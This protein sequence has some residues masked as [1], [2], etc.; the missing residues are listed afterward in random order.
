[1]PYLAWSDELVCGIESVDC[2]HKKLVQLLNEVHEAVSSG[3][4]HEALINIF[5]EL[6]DYTLVHFN[7]EEEVFAAGRY[8]RLTEHKALH[9]TLTQQVIERRQELDA[10]QDMFLAAEMLYFLKE[11]LTQHIL[12][13]DKAGCRY[14]LEHAREQA[15]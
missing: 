14:I 8:P 7:Q 3:E 10:G 15:A 5:D 6:I 2:Q 4:V 9:Q 1:M 13:D 11:W 12:V